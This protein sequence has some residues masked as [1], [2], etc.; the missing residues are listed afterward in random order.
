MRKIL[1]LTLIWLATAGLAASFAW[2]QQEP[3]LGPFEAT[4][5]DLCPVCGMFVYKHPNWQAQIVFKDKTRSFFCAPKCMFKYYFDI[6]KYNPT[7]TAGDIAE[8]WVTD[9]FTVKPVDG[10]KAFYVMGSTMLGPMGHELI[11]HVSE[12]AARYFSNDHGGKRILRFDE[13]DLELV[14]SLRF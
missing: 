5:K 3:S 7:K 6:G 13:I 14:E 1:S 8:A 4:K 9:Y 12:K 11:P 10:F 2:P